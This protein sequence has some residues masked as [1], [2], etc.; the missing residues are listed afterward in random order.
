MTDVTTEIAGQAARWVVEEGLDYGTAKRRAVKQLGLGARV[1]MPSNDELE[2]AVMDYIAVFCTDTQAAELAALRRLAL[3]WMQRLAVFRPH[4][5]G[6][7]WRGSATKHSDIYLQL[8]CD[9]C[10]SAELALIDQGVVYQ[11]HSATG[12]RGDLINVLSVQDTSSALDQEIGVHL[13][14]H[15][16]DDVRG[17]L[18]VDVKGRASMGNVAA[19]SR[20]M[21]EVTP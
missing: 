10:K 19:L 15:D 21:Q 14:I 5:S 6:A 17:A 20:L 1:S 8:F 16:Y 9:D 13:M 4:V 7:V 3:V 12:F 2:E 11:A 18:K